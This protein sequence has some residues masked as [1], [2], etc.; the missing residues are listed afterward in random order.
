[1]HNKIFSAKK[2]H[3]IFLAP[4]GQLALRILAI[5]SISIAL[6][7]LT[8]DASISSAAFDPLISCGN[9]PATPQEGCQVN[10]I[11]TTAIR[12]I[13]Y[14]FAAIGVI[15]VG[16]VVYGGVLMVTSGG[17]QASVAKGKKAMVNSLIGMGI[18]L[19]SVL[20]VRTVFQLLQFNG[21]VD[22]LDPNSIRKQN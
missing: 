3:Y 11:F 13:N 17:N 15:S 4:T 2:A 9:D 20:V 1:M 22:P 12:L 21:E 5:I 10:D 8:T 7:V 16:G 6:Q 18:V 19:V 14:L